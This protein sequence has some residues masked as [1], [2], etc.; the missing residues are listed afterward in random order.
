MMT[1]KELFRSVERR[2]NLRRLAPETGIH[3]R[4]YTEDPPRVGCYVGLGNDG[5]PGSLVQ[6]YNVCRFHNR[7]H[8][9]PEFWAEI[10][11]L[12]REFHLRDR[13]CS[14]M[15]SYITW[16]ITRRPRNTHTSHFILYKDESGAGI[17]LWPGSESFDED[18]IV[19]WAEC[20]SI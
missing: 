15:R 2:A 16:R 9:K 3:W 18:M 4:S 8:D 19:A 7:F 5:K 11:V 12:A 17:V 10:P 1:I 13:A 20:P 6:G 14:D